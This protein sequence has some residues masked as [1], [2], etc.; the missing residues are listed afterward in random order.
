MKKKK[1]AVS[2]LSPQQSVCVLSRNPPFVQL[3][4]YSVA[5]M[6]LQASGWSSLYTFI[7][8]RPLDLQ[9]NKKKKNTTHTHTPAVIWKVKHVGKQRDEQKGNL[10]Y[11]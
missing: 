9:L 5:D 11:Q 10:K 7:Y 2:E 3:I 1:K 4:S 6:T 8:P